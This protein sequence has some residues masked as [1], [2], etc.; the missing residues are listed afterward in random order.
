MP[1]ATLT[2]VLPALRP[3]RGQQKKHGKNSPELM[4]D[5]FTYTLANLMIVLIKHNKSILR[6]MSEEYVLETRNLV[7]EFKAFCRV[8][9]VNLE[10]PQRPYFTALIGPTAQKGPQCFNLLTKFLIPIR[11]QNLVPMSRY[12]TMNPPLIAAKAVAGRFRFRRCSLTM[13]AL[14]KQSGWRCQAFEGN[15]FSFWKSATAT[16]TN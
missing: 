9:D 16:E 8:N 12:P 2:D 3:Q 7:K 14:E 13:A 4:I 15:S 5:R 10:H 6:L 11:G 1:L